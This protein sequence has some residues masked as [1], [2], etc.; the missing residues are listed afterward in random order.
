MARV[1]ND[2]FMVCEDCIMII[3]N[4]DASGMTDARA[5]EVTRALERAQGFHG[6][7]VVPG[8]S[9]KGSEF[10][11]HPCACCRCVGGARHHCVILG[12]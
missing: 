3:A 11:M 7:Y 6:G 4:G 8:D 5:E 2:H 9:D 1:I 10:S 12:A